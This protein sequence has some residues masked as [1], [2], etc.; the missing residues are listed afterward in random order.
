MPCLPAGTPLQ[1]SLVFL[2]VL[3]TFPVSSGCGHF[4]GYLGFL[5]K[6][7][8]LENAYQ[9]APQ[10]K[11]LR[12]LA[13]ENCFRL[14]GPL[15]LDQQENIPL[16]AAAVTGTF[17][18]EEV[19]VARE[20]LLAFFFYNFFIPEG[21]Y[22]LFFFAD[23]DR[24]GLFEAHE[25]VG[26]TPPDNPI[27]VAADRTEDGF[28]VEGPRVAIDLNRPRHSDFPLQTRVTNRSHTFDSLEDDF[29]DARYGQMGLYRPTALIAHTQGF[30][31]GLEEFD[32]RKT[33]VI[34]VHGIGGTPQDWKYTVQGMDRTRFQPWFFY[35]PSG[36]PLER[37]GL[38]LARIISDIGKI[39]DM[40]LKGVV[41]VAHGMG[42]LVGQAAVN[43]LC[44][45]GTPS[46]L[47]MYISFSTPYGGVEGA[48][49]GVE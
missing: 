16:L 13:P 23:L 2:M 11:L 43:K 24:N 10:G 6:Q 8:A 29:F 12:E 42:G 19:V 22:T 47:K 33:L 5:H 44:R 49:I 18:E 37:L 34:F 31:F 28:T 26:Q 30:L 39:P 40:K 41:I 20:V 4:S 9:H 21:E 35:Y 32:L 1:P 48:K 17:G 45:D 15:V 36:L 3:L 7:K 25:L 38:L 14:Q 46:Y 27:R